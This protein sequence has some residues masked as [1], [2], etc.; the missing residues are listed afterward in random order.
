MKREIIRNAIQCKL[1]GEVIESKTRHMFVT[2]KCGACSVDGGHDYLR[3]CFKE[4][5]CYVELSETI[6]VFTSEDE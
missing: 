2:C 1:C 5:G 6:E 4:E 3:R